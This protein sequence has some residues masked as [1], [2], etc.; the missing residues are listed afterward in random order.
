MIKFFLSSFLLLLLLETV[1]SVSTDLKVVTDSKGY[2]A[3]NELRGYYSQQHSQ[4]GGYHKA[5][6]YFNT[7]VPSF[8]PDQAG[9]SMIDCKDDKIT[10][11]FNNNETIKQINDWPNEVILLISH[12][13][14]CFGETTTQFFMTKDR[15][16]DPS[17]KNVTFTVK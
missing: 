17:N 10:L 15:T 5:E 8:N 3:S 16:V 12:K 6:I 4:G 1:F 14:E 2:E 9:V 7:K 13:W 11:N